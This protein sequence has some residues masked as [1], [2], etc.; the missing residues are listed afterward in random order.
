MSEIIEKPM[1]S[2]KA[3]AP[4]KLQIGLAFFAFILIGAAEGGVGVLIP[5]LRRFYG[6]DKATVSLIFLAGTS[7]YL[8]AAF[9]SGPLTEKLGQKAFL[10]LGTTIFLIAALT[11][12]LTPP[13]PVVVAVWV[14][15]GC[16]IAMID[17]G[18]NSYIAGTPRP[19]KLLNY[20]HAFY[21][22]G[23]LLGPLVASTI[24]A[25]NLAWNIT[26]LV[27]ITVALLTLAGFA[28]LYNNGPKTQ[29]DA[30]NPAN[31]GSLLGQVLKMRV[32][33]ITAFFLIFYV[34]TEVSLGNWSYSYL[35]EERHEAPILSGWFITAY[36]L[37]L[38]LGRLTLA[39]LAERLGNKRLIQ[40]CLVGV[41]AGVLLIWLFPVTAISAIGLILAGFSLG[42][43]FP[44]TIAIISDLVPNS[45]RSSAIGF[46][47][48]LGSMGAAFLPWVAGNLAEQVGLWSLMPYVI[49]TTIVM[50][51]L[52]LTLEATSKKK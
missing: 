17:A 46:I 49:G 2:D 19:A 23:A 4:L 18:L 33:W 16:G 7:G 5:S 20:L 38:T 14:L 42:P 12:S 51:G 22:I 24:L 29:H 52:W 27:W 36:W 40:V 10:M 47:I 9:S 41:V 45:L 37:G 25:F 30:T 8:L 48:S 15:I 21:G 28:L 31:G 11:V 3:A 6:I 26:Y 50:L 35:T 43:I 39:N 1:V 44:T 13:F 32:I 34:G